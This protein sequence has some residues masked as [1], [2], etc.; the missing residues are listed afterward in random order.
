MEREVASRRVRFGVFDLDVRTG[1]LC[2]CGVPLGLQDQ[3]FQILR[4]LVLDPGEL[5]T[6]ERLQEKLWPDGTVVDF[7]HRLNAGV[8]KLRELLGDSARNPRFIE[9]LP[10]KG[11]RFIAPV[12]SIEE[13]APERPGLPLRRL[14]RRGLVAVGVTVIAAKLSSAWPRME[15]RPLQFT[16]RQ[17]TYSP[18]P[19]R[20]P[21]LSPDGARVAY[22]WK[23]DVYVRH[24]G[25]AAQEPIPITQSQE[26]EWNPVWSPDG[27]KL[28]FLRI[29]ARGPIRAQLILVPPIAGA[30]ETVLG[31]HFQRGSAGSIAWSP[32]GKFIALNCQMEPESHRPS[33]ICIY[34]LE[35]GKYHALTSPRNRAGDWWPVFSPDGRSIAYNAVN[36][37]LYVLPV[38]SDMRPQ[39][40][41]VA[42]GGD[43]YYPV[44]VG[45]SP[46]GEEILV[47][48]R[49]WTGE[50]GLWR[51][52]PKVDAEPRLERLGSFASATLWQSPAGQVRIVYED[53]RE[54]AQIMRVDLAQSPPREP[55]P[56]TRSTEMDI[57]PQFSPDG[58][59]VAFMSNRTGPYGVWVCTLNDCETPDLLAVLP[60]FAGFSIPLWSP[61]GDRI[62]VDAIHRSPRRDAYIV[63]VASQRVSPSL[64]ELGGRWPSWTHD[65]ESIYY[66]RPEAAGIWKQHVARGEA[67]LVLEG[68]GDGP[69]AESPDGRFLYFLHR[70]NLMRADIAP[71]GA[72]GEPVLLA[73]QVVSFAPASQ[74]VYFREMAGPVW[75]LDTADSDRRRVAEAPTPMPSPIAVSPDER[76]LLY[77]DRQQPEVNLVLLESVQ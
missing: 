45:W 64:T 15:R 40:P 30:T 7:D 10:K 19:E 44:P 11:Y 29:M 49:M 23:G 37:G 52:A 18:G 56:L 20:M 24:L 38:S 65:G 54:S 71:A 1:E 36:S 4:E 8:Q 46:D 50:E 70:R 28:A 55:T 57:N 26:I 77:A 75:F 53:V 60:P 43:W 32:D 39:G 59:R 69:T 41:P 73:Q 34:S 12:E 48:S 47:A 9:T 5:V 62:A 35:T 6:R 76:W 21:S 66:V 63:D 68:F 42:I 67:T 25:A 27:T 33:Q 61:R 17:L 22:Q 31:E 74:G 72:L 14:S 13:E 51:V 3:P 58:M 16:R 2:K